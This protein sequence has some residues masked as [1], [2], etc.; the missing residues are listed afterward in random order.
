MQKHKAS[1][2]ELILDYL[3]QGNSI[4]PLEALNRFGCLRL[5]ARIYEL[6]KAN[7]QIEMV[8][9]ETPTG[10]HVAEYRLKE[11]VN[12]QLSLLEK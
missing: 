11:T 1:Q 3:K 4:T 5:G 7:Y 6:K 12:P 9:K 2:G 8:L 10:K